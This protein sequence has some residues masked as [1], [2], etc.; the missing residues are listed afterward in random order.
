LA[1]GP[2]CYQ[3]FTAQHMQAFPEATGGDL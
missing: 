3:A 2:V 1:K